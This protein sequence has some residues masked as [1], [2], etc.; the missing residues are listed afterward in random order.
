MKFNI[1]KISINYLLS[2]NKIVQLALHSI[3]LLFFKIV[4]TINKY[5]AADGNGILIIS[6]HRLGDTVFTIPAIKELQRKYPDNLKIVCYP[7]SVSIYNLEFK[8]I[9]IQSIRKDDFYFDGRILKSEIKKNVKNLKPSMVVDITGSMKSASIIFNLRVKEIIG[10][11][12]IQ[13]RTLYDLFAEF[14]QS[15]KLIDIYLDVVKLKVEISGEKD[16]IRKNTQPNKN[17]KVLIHPFAGWKEK[18]WNLKKFIQL[19]ERIRESCPVSFV[20]QKNQLSRDIICEIENLNIEVIQTSSVDDLVECIQD[21]T[22]FIGNDSGP[23]NVANYLNKPTTTIFSATNSDYTSTGCEHHKI[24]QNK[25]GCSAKDNEKFCAIGGM[26][27][28]CSG[29]QCM[30][31][32]EV[33]SVVP[34]INNLVQTGFRH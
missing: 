5:L 16:F 1:D 29:V 31:F 23:V 9:D 19:A 7:E 8:N 30:N 13:F 21:S 27:Y 34:T 24:I 12:G 33:E 22:L 15:P 32:L 2:Q 14:R 4:R 17:G 20:V 25:V 26:F 3:M 10:T 11:N 28:K 6:L 18:E